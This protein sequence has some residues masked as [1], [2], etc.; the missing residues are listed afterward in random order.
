MLGGAKRTEM[1]DKTGQTLKVHQALAQALS[2]NGVE[3]LFG[4]MGDANMFMVDSFIRDCGGGF[5]AAANEAG[6]TLMAIGYAV[7]S[8]KVG[9]CSVT[10]GPAMTNTITA[11]VEGVKGQAPI[12]LICGD[13]D[14]EDREH[15]QN[16]AQREFVIAAGAGFEQVRSP[17]T[18]VEDVARAMR[19]AMV[20]RRPIMLN[21]PAE[22]DWLN[23]DYRPI[24]V[25]IPENRAVV[26]ESDDLDNVIGIIAAAKRPV[27]LAGRGASSAQART[28]LLKLAKRIEAPLATTLKGKDLFRGE[29]YNLGVCGTVSSPVAV[30]VIMES[31]CLI[32]FG[33]GLNRYTTSRGSFL[34]GKRIIQINLEPTEVG[35][36]ITPDAAL[37]GDPAGMADIIVHWLDEAEIPSSGAYTPELKERIAASGPEVV[38]AADNGN[39]TVDY[40]WALTKFDQLLAQDRVVV[41]DGGRFMVGVWKTV[42]VDGPASFLTTVNFSSIGL[43]LPYAI[44]ASYARPGR[45]IVLFTGDGG[46]MN[47][48]LAEFNTAVRCKVDLIVIVCNDSAYGAEYVK[49]RAKELSPTNIFFDWPDFAPVAVALG[50]EGVTVKS[51]EDFVLAERALRQRRGPLLIDVKLDPDRISN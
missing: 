23:V 3:T 14:V 28:A 49:F 45:P 26:P 33:A 2:D 10:H 21:V 1:T 15:N 4:L 6:A 48:G 13:T 18:A 37:V 12:V 11:L 17:K 19:R 41:T 31:D 39:D 44:G 32:A 40:G 22:F 46:F 30:D 36:N 27:V 34:N 51:E 24:R 16:I 25:R 7:M 20:E 9:V 43:G 29:D 50:G 5:V 35:R 8:G 42:G 47:G 38:N